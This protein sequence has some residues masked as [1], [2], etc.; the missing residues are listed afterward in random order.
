MV[1]GPGALLGQPG[2]QPVVQRFVAVDSYE[3]DIVAYSLV[4][5]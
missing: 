5:K 1:V 4:Y 3:G 2:R